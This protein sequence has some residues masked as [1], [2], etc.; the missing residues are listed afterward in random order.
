M[1]LPVDIENH[2]Q[3][4]IA[5]EYEW[6]NLEGATLMAP[7]GAKLVIKVTQLDPCPT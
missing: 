1:K 4:Q 2:T 6:E 3:H 7:E 5:V